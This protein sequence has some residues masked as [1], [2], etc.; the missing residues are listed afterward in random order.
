MKITL[1]TEGTYPHHLG[2]V[3]VWCDQLVREIAEHQFHVLALSATGL[4]RN[5]WDL[6]SN[7]VA[8]DNLPLWSAP[9]GKRVG[10]ALRSRFRPVQERFFRSL[11]VDSDGVGFVQSLQELGEFAQGGRLSAAMSSDDAVNTLLTVGPVC[12]DRAHGGSAGQLTV[13]DAVDVLVLLKHF[14]RP[15]AVPPP[16]ADLCHSVANGLGALP[17]LAAKWAHGT[18]FLLTEHGLY[19]RER[20]LSY[21][22]GTLSQP[23]RAIVLRFFR[24]LVQTAYQHADL[25][26]PGSG[27]NRLWELANG[28]PPRRICPV[29]NGID[30]ELFPV[31]TTEPDVPTLSWIGRI[32]PLKDVE[33]LLRAFALVRASVP[34]C[35]LRVF[36]PVP[37]GGEEYMARCAELAAELDL[38][39]AAT[40]EGRVGSPIEAYQAGHVVVLTSISEGLPYTV[41]EAMATGRPVVATDVGGVGEAV[42]DTGIL[43]PPRNP[44]AVAAACVHLLANADERRAR[45]QAARNRVVELF[46]AKASFDTYRRLYRE[47]AQRP[48]PK[49]VELSA[50]PGEEERLI[51]DA[52][53][54][55]APV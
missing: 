7:V 44:S 33:T 55:V 12:S 36:G 38:N 24:L 1:I 35:R 15:L 34:D 40:F 23:A 9:A 22:P 49:V 45:G 53:H 54:Q 52:A 13:S 28:T 39:G 4:E 42:G 21:K 46:T 17:A 26:A 6:P 50:R 3:S 20:Y 11:A 5:I 32:D 8:A 43:V 25:V 51:K 37:G 29:R 27:Y 31:A 30:P 2:G 14:L 41:L 19:L 48:Q 18:P 16:V 47:V 10:R